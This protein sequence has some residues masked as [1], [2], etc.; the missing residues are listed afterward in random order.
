M[1]FGIATA[2][3]GD[4]EPQFS[5]RT[6]L[7]RKHH[8]RETFSLIQSVL[9]PH[10]PGS[11]PSSHCPM[12]YAA[13]AQIH[14]P[15]MHQPRLSCARDDHVCGR[16]ADAKVMKQHRDATS[17]RTWDQV[18]RYRPHVPRRSPQRHDFRHPATTRRHDPCWQPRVARGLSMS[19]ADSASIPPIATSTDDKLCHEGSAAQIPL[20]CTWRDLTMR[21]QAWPRV[22]LQIAL[23]VRQV[24]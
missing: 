22:R 7:T 20:W 3:S 9:V 5:D 8:M 4:P 11:S 6:P 18:K 24:R 10:G 12:P 23:R 15:H 1:V 17:H 2:Y 19:N 14:L 16:I 21:D 13:A